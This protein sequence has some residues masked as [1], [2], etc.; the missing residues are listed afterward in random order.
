MFTVVEL[1]L[2]DDGEVGELGWII[3]DDGE[4][5]V[6]VVVVVVDAALISKHKTE[7]ELDLFYKERIIE[8]DED[9]D[10]DDD[11]NTDN[12]S[13]SDDDRLYQT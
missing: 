2:S 13:N 1:T 7:T 10:S 9:D 8:N 11:K 12:N 5:V 4:L 6:V 3:P